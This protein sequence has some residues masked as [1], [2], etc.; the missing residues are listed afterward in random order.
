MKPRTLDGVR[1]HILGLRGFIFVSL[2]APREKGAGGAAAANS[3]NRR[4]DSTRKHAVPESRAESREVQDTAQSS[5]HPHPTRLA[6]PGES[7]IAS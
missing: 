4:G 3:M 7:C 6:G 5:I 1:P 2:R